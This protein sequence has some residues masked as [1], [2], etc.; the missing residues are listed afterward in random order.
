M[1]SFSLN[2]PLDQFSRDDPEWVVCLS[3]PSATVTERAGDC[4][5][6]SISQFFF[7]FFFLKVLTIF[8]G[9]ESLF[10]F[11]GSVLL[12]QPTVHSGGQTFLMSQALQ[13]AVV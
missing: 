9:F 10:G 12:N 13:A 7:Y 5:S 6:K 2:Q 8:L 3:P 4:W 1:G 11:L